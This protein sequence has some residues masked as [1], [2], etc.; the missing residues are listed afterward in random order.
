M[1]LNKKVN[2]WQWCGEV[3]G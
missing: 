1:Y 3:E 2:F